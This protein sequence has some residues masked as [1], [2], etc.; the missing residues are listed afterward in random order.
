MACPNAPVR[1]SRAVSA[2]TAV[3][4]PEQAP[5]DFVAGVARAARDFATEAILPGSE[6]S[7]LWLARRRG[8]LPV[9]LAAPSAETVEL[10]TDKM[11]VLHLA[12]GY[13]LPGPVSTV[14]TPEALAAQAESFRYPVILKPHRSRLELSDHRLAY[15]KT[16]R[17]RSNEDPGRRWQAFPRATGWC[18]RT[19]R[20]S[21]ARFRASP[22]RVG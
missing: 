10:A 6:A 21:S 13:G 11:R 2:V 5:D 15:F 22:G 14:G 20:G 17:I 12:A 7:L 16:R 19:S 9:P 1:Y 8:A 18:S 4:D 3:P